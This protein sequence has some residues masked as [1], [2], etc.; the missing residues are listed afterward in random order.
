MKLLAGSGEWVLPVRWPPQARRKPGYTACMRPGLLGRALGIGVR[1]ASQR[2]L[3]PAPAPL[4]A[5]EERQRSEERVQKGKELGRRALSA[6]K[7]GK[8][9]GRAVWN[10]FAHAG[11]I[12]WLEVTGMFFFLFAGLFAQHLW[13]LRAAWRSGPE[14]GHFLVY[15]AFSLV[16]L[17]FTVSSFARARAR[18]RRRARARA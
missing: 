7:G 16:F 12:L 10:P 18:A 9:L 2:V 6:G 3:P 1:L 13:T 15:A 11:S 17:Y 8:S 14:H 5:A 4:S